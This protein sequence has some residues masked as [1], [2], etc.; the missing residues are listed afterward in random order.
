MVGALIGGITGIRCN[1]IAYVLVIIWAYAGILI[2]H[3]S[4]QGYALQYPSVFYTALFCIAFLLMTLVYIRV[5]A[6]QAKQNAGPD[7]A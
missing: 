1:D 2:R 4:E 6:V 5:K 7:H 3:V